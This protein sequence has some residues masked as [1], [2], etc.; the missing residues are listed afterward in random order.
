M[1][2]DG[3]EEQTM[4]TNEIYQTVTN[5]IIELLESQ[6]ENWNRPWIAFG[7]D[8]DFAR[9]G[10]SNRYYRGINQFLLS[11]TLMR[12]GFFKNAWMTFNQVR[13]QG[14]YVR[15]G[16]KSSPIVFY[17]TAY[18]DNNNKYVSP[19]RVEGMSTAQ[20]RESGIKAIPILK[21]YRVF[22]VAQ[23]EGLDPA[24]YEVAPQE[25]LQDFEKDERAEQLIQATG[26][27][28]EIT[29]SNRAYYDRLADKI[30][31]PL[32]EQF[33]GKS[34]PF[35]ATALHEL[36]HWTGHPSRLNRE[37]GVGFGDTEYAKEELVA[38]LCSAFCCAALG[39]SKT[40]SNNAAYIKSWL[41]ILKE[42][43]KA[44]V[45]ASNQAQKAADF[46]LDGTPYAVIKSDL[47]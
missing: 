21:L 1:G 34:E 4:K 42:D 15:K 36:G 33:R 32:R 8:N 9:N 17:K 43:N 30:Q 14:G 35:Y 37:M 26:A 7:Q 11:F 16:E 44:V 41:G 20:Y 10:S 40:M 45:R 47:S 27:A 39:F 5:T 6:Q 3:R 24:F 2:G 28:I 23:T 12:K 19:D 31:L 18:I 25:P 22:N 38:E 13:T 29:E 46:I